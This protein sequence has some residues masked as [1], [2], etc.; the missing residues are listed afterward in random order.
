MSKETTFKYEDIKIIS[1]KMIE[2][3]T[4][5]TDEERY[6]Q[7]LNIS[8]VQRDI[9]KLQKA[10]ETNSL[11]LKHYTENVLN[12]INVLRKQKEYLESVLNKV[13]ND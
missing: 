9:Q 1:D 2:L 11:Q 10:V 6:T 5:R 7:E 12:Q 13:K 4:V 3:S 8:D